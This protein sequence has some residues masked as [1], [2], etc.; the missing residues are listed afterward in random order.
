MYILQHYNVSINVS[1]SQ[2]QIN[3]NKK[4]QQTSIFNSNMMSFF[5]FVNKRVIYLDGNISLAQTRC[6]HLSQVKKSQN[7]II[8]YTVVNVLNNCIKSLKMINISKN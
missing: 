8:I 1:V 5:C 4:I 7:K 3:L 2:K 6:T